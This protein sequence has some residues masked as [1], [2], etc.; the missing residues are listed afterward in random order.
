MNGFYCIILLE[1]GYI[2]WCNIYP[3]FSKKKNVKC[4]KRKENA[5]VESHA[6]IGMLAILSNE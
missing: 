5:Q 4:P 2:V 3:A 6:F 1:Q